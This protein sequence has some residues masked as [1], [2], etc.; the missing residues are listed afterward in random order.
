MSTATLRSQA[1]LEAAISASAID[2]AQTSAS[3]SVDRREGTS[4][5]VNHRRSLSDQQA[6]R[7]RAARMTTGEENLHTLLRPSTTATDHTTP[8]C[9]ELYESA[10]PTPIELRLWLRDRNQPPL[11]A[12]SEAS[13]EPEM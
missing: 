1:I 6:L 7:R 10:E 8:F 3:A 4:A 5:P 11:Q 12:R 9:V 13:D 2:S